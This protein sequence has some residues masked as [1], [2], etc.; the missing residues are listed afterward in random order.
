LRVA[1]YA[2]LP[3][4]TSAVPRRHSLLTPSCSSPWIPILLLAPSS[5]SPSTLAPS[6]HARSLPPRSLAPSTLAPSLH[7][8]VALTPKP[9]IGEDHVVLL[10]A[11][12]R[13]GQRA[14]GRGG[15]L[16]SQRTSFHPDVLEPLCDIGGHPA[17]LLHRGA[18]P[19]HVHGR[20]HAHFLLQEGRCS[21][22]S[23]LP[24]APSVCLPDPPP[25]PPDL[26]RRILS[27]RT[28]QSR[29]DLHS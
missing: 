26:R 5:L 9:N 16:P 4:P 10:H 18:D 23:P 25:R 14:R 27:R 15:F 22:S 13:R 28:D 6:L 7:R 11:S 12:G 20:R 29:P 17:L 21:D 2:V 8:V 24:S 1:R 19:V 3:P